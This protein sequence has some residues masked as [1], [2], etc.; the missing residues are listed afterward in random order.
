MEAYTKKQVKE[1]MLK[2]FKMGQKKSEADDYP[3]R[4]WIVGAM[5][6]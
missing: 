1:L 4:L 3:I 2:A 5:E 6:E